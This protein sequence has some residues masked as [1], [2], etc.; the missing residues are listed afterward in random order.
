MFCVHCRRYLS[1]NI[2]QAP[3]TGGGGQHFISNFGSNFERKR[4]REIENKRTREREKENETKRQRER[5]KE[6]KEKR[7]KERA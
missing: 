6:R 5:E 1:H 2:D 3:S 7:E 4:E